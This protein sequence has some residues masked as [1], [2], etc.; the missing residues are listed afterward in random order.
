MSRMLWSLALIGLFATL[1]LVMG[2]MFTLK[3]YRMTPA[4]SRVRLSEA[5]RTQFNLQSVG[6]ELKVQPDKSYLRIAYLT[7][8]DS[9]FDISKQTR[10]MQEIADFACTNY[11]DPRERR[12]FEEI[13]VTRTEIRGSGCFQESF[14]LNHSCPNPFRAPV[15]PPDAP[16]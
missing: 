10:E 2:M 1:A 15:P 8:A 7:R 4:S 12:A 13:R 11:P 6:V 9:S 3:T 14:V 5:I 16:R